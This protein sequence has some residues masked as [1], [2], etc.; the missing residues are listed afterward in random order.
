MH[1]RYAHIQ[2]TVWKNEKFS[3][4][5][6]I[7]EIKTLQQNCWF[8]EVFVKKVLENF[9]NFHKQFVARNHHACTKQFA[10]FVKAMFSLVLI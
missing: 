5:R 7:R 9:R 4:N 6:K 2:V 3:I 10:N 1:M 8:H